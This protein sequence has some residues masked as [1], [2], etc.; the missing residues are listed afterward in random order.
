M[1]LAQYLPHIIA[2][3]LVAFEYCSRE[4]RRDMFGIHYE[5]TRKHVKDSEPAPGIA[6]F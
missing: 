5:A 1:K 2:P 3:S 6:I 4:Q